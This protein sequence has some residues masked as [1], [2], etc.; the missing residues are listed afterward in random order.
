[1]LIST[2]ISEKFGIK[3][4]DSIE[5][6]EK[7][8]RDSSYTVEVGGVYDYQSSLA[9]FMNLDDYNKL[10][11]NKSD[12][13]TGYFSNEELTELDDDDVVSVITADDYTKL[14]DQLTVS[15]GGMM[16]LFKWFGAMFFV[17]VV[18]VLCKQVIERNF[19]S[20][21]LTKI[22]GFRNSEIGSLYIVSTSI[23]VVLGLAISVPFIDVAMRAIFKSYLYTMMTGYFPY[24][25]S[26]I[27]Y[28]VTV[29]TGIIC[30]AVVA[31]L[32]MRKVS[33]VSKSEALKNVE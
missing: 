10:F 24:V 13:F 26:P 29:A 3:T 32:Q 25:M 11:G 17:I 8:K 31:L 28:I 1:M 9:I 14:S 12:Y 5:L 33:K 15:M 18:Y 23:A 16:E 7:Y 30:Y 21:S 2:G 20:I 4:G 6:D 19:Q 27:T 22:L